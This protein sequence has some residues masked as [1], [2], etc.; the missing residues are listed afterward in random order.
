MRK[1]MVLTMMLMVLVACTDQSQSPEDQ[2]R[3]YMIVALL[4]QKLEMPVIWLT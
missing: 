2:V 1:K 3:Q 4:R